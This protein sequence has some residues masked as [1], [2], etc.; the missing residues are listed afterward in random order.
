M[1]IW[2]R[3]QTA[4]QSQSTATDQGLRSYMLKVYN[5]MASG[6]LLTG[7]ISY[8][9]GTSP[10]FLN[11]VLNVGQ[12]TVGLS[13]LGWIITFAPV[14]LVLVLGFR[15][16]RMSAEAVQM[17]FWGYAALMGLSLFSIFLVY[18]G[19]SIARVFFITAATFGLLSMVGYTTKRDLTSMHTFLFVGIWGIF[20]VSLANIF[21]KIEGLP[22]VLS[23]VGVLLALGLTAYDTQKIKETYYVTAGN[24]EATKKAAA[25][26][27][28]S[29]Y[30]DFIYLFINLLRIL[31]DRR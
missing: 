17:A 12:G 24:P 29:L 15:A 6:V 22:L 18:T 30:F 10:A 16:H 11:A 21:L 3:T 31:G 13:P 27:A 20:L 8:F 2:N 26:G 19:E 23:Y 1:N 4:A 14:A 5:Y 7:I 28:L 25:L 9:A